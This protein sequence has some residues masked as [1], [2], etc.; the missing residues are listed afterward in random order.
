MNDFETDMKIKKLLPIDP[1]SRRLIDWMEKGFL[2][3]NDFRILLRFFS[4]DC[5]LV[6]GSRCLRCATEEVFEDAHVLHMR[7]S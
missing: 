4:T 3:P 5:V 7:I 1:E 6:T 2:Y